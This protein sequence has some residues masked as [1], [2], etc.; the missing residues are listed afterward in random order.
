M[1]GRRRKLFLTAAIILFLIALSYAVYMQL[2]EKST[3]EH[4]ID[5][6]RK[7]L[8]KIINKI[9]GNYTSFINSQ[10]PYLESPTS[11]RTEFTAKITNGTESLGLSDAAVLGKSKLIVNVSRD[12]V[13]EIT[14]TRADLMIEKTPFLKARLY[15]DPETIWLSVPDILPDRYFSVKRDKL[16]DV[17]DRFS[18][19]VKPLKLL[20]GSEIADKL[21]FDEEALMK[22]VNKLWD[23][24]SGYLTDETVMEN[25]VR[26]ISFKDRTVEG[27]EILVMLDEEKASALMKEL[28]TAIAEDDLLLGYTYGNLANI[29]K[30]LDDAGLFRLFD[31][32]DENWY[33]ALGSHEMEMLRGLNVSKSIGEFREMLM[34][35]ASS[36]R[37]KDGVKMKVTADEKSNILYRTLQLDLRN[38][39]GNGSF[40]ADIK[41]GGYHAAADGSSYG[42]FGITVDKYGSDGADAEDKR[43]ELLIDSFFTGNQGKQTRGSIE[44]MY[45][46]TPAGGVR[47]E[48]NMD[49]DISGRTDEETMKRIKN[50]RLT[51]DISNENG[52]G[53][54]I[55]EIDTASW[56][57]KKLSKINRTV[58]IKLDADIPY[59]ENGDFSGS[60]R[61]VNED[62]LSIEEFSLPDFK[63]AS[64]TDISEASD[65][66]LEKIRMEIMASFGVF[67]LNNKDIIDAL[68]GWG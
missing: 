35:T 67:Y 61:L 60:L 32:L 28:L 30:L 23:I 29:S 1:S 52:D 11:S 38:D 36:Y 26:V 45:G 56:E 41:T 65:S 22:S 25:G 5:L 53:S 20:S 8:A 42:I 66:D 63:Q 27:K 44:M 54:I 57:N 10:K 24:Y 12:P 47:S 2:T 55:A 49:I 15:S 16:Y 48:I 13:K 4:Y 39:A 31:Y 40:R 51:T 34:E 50:I 14:D 58:D 19:P 17:Y 37:L 62:S 6:E 21:T 68:L 59:L 64:V 9:G 3:A 33:T 46:F 7:N 18:V 43:T